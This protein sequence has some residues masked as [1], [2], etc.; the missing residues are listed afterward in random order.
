MTTRTTV[1]AAAFVVAAGLGSWRALDAQ[2]S[3]FEVW[4]ADQSDTRP[5]FGTAR[6]PHHPGTHRRDGSRTRHASG[7]P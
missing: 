1:I 3:R 5:G 6:T 2:A 4:I 7:G